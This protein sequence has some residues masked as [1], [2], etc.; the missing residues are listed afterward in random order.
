ML[1]GE[2]KNSGSSVDQCGAQILGLD[3]QAGPDVGLIVGVCIE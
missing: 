3:E 1:L 2:D